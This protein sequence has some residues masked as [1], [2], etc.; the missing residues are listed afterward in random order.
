M[1]LLQAINGYHI[2][3]SFILP[4]ER[5][6][7]IAKWG[8]YQKGAPNWSR[9]AEEAADGEKLLPHVTHFS[10]SSAALTGE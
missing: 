1:F 6:C 4:T 8:A 7:R 10:L 2:G 3:W 9:M 5:E